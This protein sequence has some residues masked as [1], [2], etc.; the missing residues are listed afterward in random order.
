MAVAAV[1]VDCEEAPADVMS[2]EEEAV[3]VAAAAAMTPAVLLPTTPC[4]PTALP[5][6]LLPEP[7]PAALL[8]LVGLLLLPL[9]PPSTSFFSLQH[10]HGKSEQQPAPQQLAH[11]CSLM[12][13]CV[14]GNQRSKL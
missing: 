6:P 3:V 10:T 1:A 13:A 4:C 2:P 5:L 14:S 11:S 7:C 9:P 12:Q 8:L